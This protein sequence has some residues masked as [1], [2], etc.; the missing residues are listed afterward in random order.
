MRNKIK[1]NLINLKEI[2]NQNISPKK[3]KIIGAAATVPIIAAS[4]VSGVCAASCPYGIVYCPAPGQCRRYIDSDS[5]GACDLSLS[6]SGSPSSVTSA[7]SGNNSPS[8]SSSRDNSTAV[9]SSGGTNLHNGNSDQSNTSTSTAHD[10]SSGTGDSLNIGNDYHIIPVSLLI[11]GAYLFTHYLFSKGILKPQKH[12]RLWNLLLMGGFLGSGITGVLLIYMINLGI[13]L[14]YREGLTYWHVEL[15]LLMVIATLI[16][17]HIYRK[18]FKRMF[19]VLFNFKSHVN[20][21]KTNK[22]HGMSK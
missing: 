16:H 13:S 10:P 12:K 6:E 21:N 7:G 4:T 5:S 22:S 18:P 14:V 9:D 8:T 20:K 15:S 17:F 19:E 11:I 3:T 2:V 1:N